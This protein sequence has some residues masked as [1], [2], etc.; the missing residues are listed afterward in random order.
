MRVRMR[1]ILGVG[2][3]CRRQSIYWWALSIGL[4]GWLL[5]PAPGESFLVGKAAPDISGGPWLNSKPLGIS[6]LRGRVV[7]VEFWTYG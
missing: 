3:R 2:N 1:C 7:L 6:D 5:W 4:I